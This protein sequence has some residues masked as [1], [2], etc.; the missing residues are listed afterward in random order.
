MLTEEERRELD[1]LKAEVSA[2]RVCVGALF[3]LQAIPLDHQRAMDYIP[4]LVEYLKAGVS[5]EGST[6]RGSSVANHVFQEIID[7]FERKKLLDNL[8]ALQNDPSV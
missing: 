7:G 1:D 6:L 4:R 3:A 5:E 8:R 2:L